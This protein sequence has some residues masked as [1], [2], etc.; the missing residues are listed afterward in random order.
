MKMNITIE[1]SDQELMAKIIS[2]VSGGGSVTSGR[3]QATVSS[4]GS[5]SGNG[6]AA[7]IQNTGDTQSEAGNEGDGSLERAEDIVAKL[8]TQFQPVASSADAKGSRIKLDDEIHDPDGLIGVVAGLFRGRVV[9]AYDDGTGRVFAGTQ[10]ELVPQDDTEK[11]AAAPATQAAA[12]APVEEPVTGEVVEDDI[13]VARPYTR[14]EVKEMAKSIMDTLSAEA[15]Y[16]IMMEHAG[17]MRMSLVPDDMVH[18]LGVKLAA[19]LKPD[20]LG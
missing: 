16:K 7:T 12:T 20:P 4:G 18:S 11:A 6:G 8:K 2:I 5:V 10:V 1:T 17:V 13:E 14:D 3:P 9:I 15:L 19:E